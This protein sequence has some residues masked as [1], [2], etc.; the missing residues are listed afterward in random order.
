MPHPEIR[1]AYG[2]RAREYT[3]L[4]GSVADLAEP[5]R[6]TI[7]EWAQSIGGPVLD[8]GCG[9]GHWTQHLHDLGLE[10]EGVDLTP[11]FV[12][13]AQRRFPGL[14]FRVGE[15]EAL[16]VG[17]GSLGGLLAWYSTIHTE[18][19]EVPALL[20]EFARCLRPGGSLLLGFFAGERSEPFDHA[21]VTG[22]HWPVDE[23]LRALEG[24]GFALIDIRTR[25]EPGGR[26][27]AS[28][29]AERRGG[30]RT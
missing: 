2:A 26:P 13:I 10:A 29:T 17:S 25:R 16:P 22:Y 12:S 20:T 19:A 4:L 27:L 24:A 21:V 30:A 9:P 5:D 7:T 23:M 28:V 3:E 6:E 11:E 15:L 14:H 1:R 8:A 18:P